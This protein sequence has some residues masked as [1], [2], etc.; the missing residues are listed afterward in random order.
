[1]AE[2]APVVSLPMHQLMLPLGFFASLSESVLSLP[3]PLAE[4]PPP[5][6]PQAVRASTLSAAEARSRDRRNCEARRTF[7][8]RRAQER[9]ELEAGRVSG[10]FCS[11]DISITSRV[12]VGLPAE[13]GGRGRPP[14][15]RFRR[16]HGSAL[17][18]LSLRRRR[19][20]FRSRAPRRVRWSRARAAALLPTDRRRCS[21]RIQCCMGNQ[22]EGKRAAGCRSRRALL[23]G[24]CCADAPRRLPTAAPRSSHW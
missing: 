13:P 5:P 15:G 6:P 1:M 21:R 18:R 4:P 24:E 11:V 22:R 3:A 2:K 16:R 17:E 23:A 9:L 8:I 7:R 10:R 19:A 20:R 12:L 14:A